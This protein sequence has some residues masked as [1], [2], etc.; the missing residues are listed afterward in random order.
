VGTRRFCA[1]SRTS[2]TIISPV[3][4]SRIALP[5]VSLEALEQETAKTR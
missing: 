2:K 3:A 4:V 5:R 1:T